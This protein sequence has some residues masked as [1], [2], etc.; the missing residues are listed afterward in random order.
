[1]GWYGIAA[2]KG[3][4]PAILAKLRKDFDK[5]LADSEVQKMLGRLGFTPTFRNATEFA[6]FERDMAAMYRRVVKEANIQIK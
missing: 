1:M 5:I 2:P 6:D 4:D 3:L